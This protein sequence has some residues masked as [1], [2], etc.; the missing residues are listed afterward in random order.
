M[1][2]EPFERTAERMRRCGYQSVEL[3]GEPALVDAGAVSAALDRFDLSCWGALA[4]MT[5]GRD[6]CHEDAYVRRGTVEYV[7]DVVDLAAALGG[8]MVTVVPTTVGKLEP[9]ASPSREWEW[10][11]DSMRSCANHAGEH[12]LRL[13]IEPLNR[14]ETY[15]VNRVEQA[16]SVADACGPSCGVC[17]DTFHMNIEEADTLAA[18]RLAG[19]RLVNVHVADSNRLAPGLG[20]LDWP[21]LLGALAEIG[22]DGCLAVEFVPPP[23]DR[24]AVAAAAP[25]DHGIELTEGERRFMRDHAGGWLAEEDYEE[26]VAA[27]RRTLIQAGAAASPAKDAI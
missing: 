27:S 23:A 25:E 2:P 9:M 21:A 5:E 24:T 12:G 16:L 10:C 1:R 20:A 15:L 13:A 8:T 6:L 11:V 26:L 19:E 17:L 22:Y 18:V 3:A 7:K 14:F 4:L